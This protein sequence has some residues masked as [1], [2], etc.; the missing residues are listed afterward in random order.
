MSIFKKHNPTPERY[1]ES[2]LRNEVFAALGRARK[3]G[4]HSVV[5]RRS[6]LCADSHPSKTVKGFPLIGF[7]RERRKFVGV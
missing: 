5:S 1:M 2:D 6:S 3:A 4:I 7:D